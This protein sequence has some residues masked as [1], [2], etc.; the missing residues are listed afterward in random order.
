MDE[1]LFQTRRMLLHRSTYKYPSSLYLHVL[2]VLNW[3][4]INGVAGK[5]HHR[6]LHQIALS[7]LQLVMEDDGKKSNCET[8]SIQSILHKGSFF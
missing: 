8:P 5:I 2:L 4:P 6:S 7:N 3:F 1:I